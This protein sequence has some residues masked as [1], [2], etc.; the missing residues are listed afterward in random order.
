MAP[1][2][3]HQMIMMKH[4]K[5]T[6]LTEKK[7]LLKQYMKFQKDKTKLMVNTEFMNDI[8]FRVPSL[9]CADKHS[10][11]GGNTYAYYFEK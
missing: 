8:T 9:V 3:N 2:K 11:A 10:E 7:P 4:L 6:I 1:Q 5:N